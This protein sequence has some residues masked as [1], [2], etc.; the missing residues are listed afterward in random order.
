M[1]AIGA[2]GCSETERPEPPPDPIPLTL[3]SKYSTS[4]GLPSDEVFGIL[5][6]SQNRLWLST[7]TGI[8]MVDGAQSDTLDD[9]DGVPNRQCRGLAERS[10]KIFVGTWGGGV[11]YYDGSPLWTALPI[12][13]GTEEGVVS[14]RVFELCADDTSLWI[15]TVAG[16]S[17]Y[18]DNDA[19]PMEER[20]LDYTDLI[21]AV[22][23]TSCFINDHPTRGP[24][25]W[26]GLQEDGIAVL[27]LP[28]MYAVSGTA[29]PFLAV[30]VG[31]GGAIMH[32][33]GSTWT[34]P[35]SPTRNPLRGIFVAS[36]N[37]ANAVGD[38]GTWVSYDGNRWVVRSSPTSKDLNAIAGVSA[39][40][41]WAVGVGGTVVRH[42]GVIR[43]LISTPFTTDLNG[44]W[45]PAGNLIY[46][47]GAEG[48]IATFNGF[49]DWTVTS[50]T[51]HDL[52]AVWGTAVNNV[53]AV[54]DSGTIFN[55]D[56]SS[57]SSM[58][59]NTSRSIKSIWGTSA[60]DV[61][62]VGENALVLHYDGTT[63]SQMTSGAS[64]DL[65]LHGIW[66]NSATDMFTV[67]ALATYMNGSDRFLSFDGTSWSPMRTGTQRFLRMERFRASGGG[68]PGD[69]ISDLVHDVQVDNIWATMPTM[70]ISGVDLAT[71][72]WTHLR[73]VDGFHSDLA[74]SIDIRANRDI[75]VGTQFGAS[76]REP[77]GRIVNFIKGSGIP[78]PR[79]RK[80]YVAPNDDVWLSFIGAGVARVAKPDTHK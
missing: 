57:W 24:E 71:S 79:V 26:F 46:M 37:T 80:V 39:S 53:F 21:G 47:V 34:R 54:G 18:R 73:Q 42:D 32:Y 20:W 35:R 12:Q 58:A 60:S 64:P 44:V 38:G 72:K 45:L 68:L 4:N 78:D 2:F 36:E 14:D 75:W 23:V 74:L 28:A 9:F 67:G 43:R 27:R 69:Q 25:V 77:S 17:Q 63:W 51:Q 65:S 52:N 5:V 10:G 76:R 6:D 8:L 19:L 55:W 49:S 59:S 31:D 56:G 11:A 16:V 40:A 61:Y 70:G 13:Q 29:G 48:T 50:V 22:P 41:A 7:N 66:G 30:A 3:D 33:D 1:V 62:A 15:C